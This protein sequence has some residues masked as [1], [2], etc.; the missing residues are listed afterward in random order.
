MLV[1][2]LFTHTHFT[3]TLLSEMNNFLSQFIA[4]DREAKLSS[5][6]LNSNSNSVFTELLF[7]SLFKNSFKMFK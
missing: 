4:L 5:S 6:P 2:T 1:G 3:P 7:V